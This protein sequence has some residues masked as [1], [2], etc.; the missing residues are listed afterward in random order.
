MTDGNC[1]S[2]EI[3]EWQR[4]Y[5]STRL[6]TNLAKLRQK[7]LDTEAAMCKRRLQ[8]SLKVTG[9][10]EQ[11]EISAINEALAYLDVLRRHLCKGA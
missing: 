9:S 11:D 3:V 7:I 1:F 5:R 10:V 6:E 4:L 8:L 2:P